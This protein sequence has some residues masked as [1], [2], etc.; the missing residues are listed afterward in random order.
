MRMESFI[1]LLIYQS[2]LNYHDDAHE[3]G[4]GR[5]TTPTSKTY[6]RH[7]RREMVWPRV[8]RDVKRSELA[9]RELELEVHD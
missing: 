2:F 1:E 4:Y 8:N 7:P 5:L 9:T 6:D 3:A